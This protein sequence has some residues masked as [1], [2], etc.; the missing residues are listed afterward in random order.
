MTHG[1]VTQLS[2]MCDIY[3]HM[4]HI[5]T[6]H[7]CIHIYIYGICAQ[8]ITTIYVPDIYND[9]CATAPRVS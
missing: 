8:F 9:N 1:A 6:C 3:T 7:I 2:H 5:Y 4:S